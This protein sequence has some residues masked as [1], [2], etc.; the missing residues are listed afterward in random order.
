MVFTP[1][2]PGAPAVSARRLVAIA[3]GC[4]LVCF[5]L[6]LPVMRWAG[7]MDWPRSVAFAGLVTLGVGVA[8]LVVQ[9]VVRLGE[10][11]IDRAS[12][13]LGRG[14]A[15]LFPRFAPQERTR[16][17][18]A[19]GALLDGVEA[20]LRRL[21]WWQ[22]DPPPLREQA[23]AGELRSYLDAPSFELWLQCVFLPNARDMVAADALPPSSSVGV[24][25]MRQYDYHSHVPEAQ[26]LLR[27]LQRFDV[28]ANELVGHDPLA[29]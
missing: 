14:R 9:L 18:V 1:Y 7:G 29:P 17:L 5:L 13:A 28:E 19:L 2:I 24:M 3:A 6:L 11:L 8:L 25:A 20:E 12:A 10:W 4:M 15:R 26:E 23:L 21:D 16:R 27:L 22:A